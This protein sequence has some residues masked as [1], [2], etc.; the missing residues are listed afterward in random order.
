M[1]E[2]KELEVKKE[3]PLDIAKAS[4]QL[5]FL[6]PELEVCDDREIIKAIQ[7]AIQVLGLNPL[8]KECYFVPFYDKEKK[9]H[10]ISI[11]VSYLEYLKRAQASGKLNGFNVSLGKDDYG[12]YSETTIYR[13]DWDKPFIWR[14]Y[15]NEV[16]K[17]T[18]IWDSMGIFM[19]RKVNLAQAFRIAFAEV[20]SELPY[21]KEELE[22]IKET[23]Q[24]TPEISQEEL[25]EI[26]LSPEQIQEQEQEQEQK[27]KQ[28]QEIEIPSKEE[29]VKPWSKPEDT[30]EVEAVEIE[31]KPETKSE[32]KTKE[33]LAPSYLIDKIKKET[34]H[35][36]YEERIALF[37]KILQR[38][39]KILSELTENEAKKILFALKKFQKKPKKGVENGNQID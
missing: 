38:D 35:L 4:E 15:L 25:P 11:I 3:K 22:V 9:T 37:S 8:K 39:V 19:L 2:K 14:T 12:V 27:I 6:F 29:I 20:I 32:T 10:K 17:N 30:F 5:K 24:E 28:E 26:E 36:S 21:T 16:K 18:R 13:K 1:E 33:N 34:A 31:V 7:I 23:S